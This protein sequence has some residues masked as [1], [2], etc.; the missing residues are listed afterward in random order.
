MHERFL[1]EDLLL[2]C[3]KSVD[4]AAGSYTKAFTDLDKW[5][6]ACRMICVM[7]PKSFDAVVRQRDP[8]LWTYDENAPLRV[9]RCED[10]YE[11]VGPHA[12]KPMGYVALTCVA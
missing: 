7:D 3:T 5:V 10:E 8:K 2:R 12:P 4:M 9:E 11:G 6:N 1:R